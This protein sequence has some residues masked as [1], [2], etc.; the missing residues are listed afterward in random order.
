[1]ACLIHFLVG[2]RGGCHQLCLPHGL[3]CGTAFISLWWLQQ[4]HRGKLYPT[5]AWKAAWPAPQNVVQASLVVPP[6]KN[7]HLRWSQMAAA[8]SWVGLYF[9]SCAR[10]NAR[11][12]RTFSSWDRCSSAQSS[13]EVDLGP[14]SGNALGC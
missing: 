3:W 8:R 1:M 12:S 7:L 6:L 10:D 2:G 11:G 13:S 5:A 4:C 9:G 14:D